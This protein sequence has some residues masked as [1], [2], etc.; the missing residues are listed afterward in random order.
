MKAEEERS[1][2]DKQ[3]LQQRATVHVHHMGLQLLSGKKT[4]IVNDVLYF[5]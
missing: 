4:E 3:N 2:E 1:E 5:F